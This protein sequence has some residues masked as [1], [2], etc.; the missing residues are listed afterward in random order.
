[1]G[2]SRKEQKD[3]KTNF[4]ALRLTFPA[5]QTDV[6][7][8]LWLLCSH[9]HGAFVVNF[10]PR[11]RTLAKRL[12]TQSRYLRVDR[13]WGRDSAA[14]ITG[15]GH[16]GNK[17][18]LSANDD[19]TGTTYATGFEFGMV[20]EKLATIRCFWGCHSWNRKRRYKWMVQHKTDGPLW[21]DPGKDDL[22]KL[23]WQNVCLLW[24]SGT[25]VLLQYVL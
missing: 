19:K 15:K 8:I 13:W 4:T 2:K 14:R 23:W 6:V 17:S 11:M 16:A 20:D 12:C 22:G 10:L 25:P 24:L 5:H 3:H 9:G 1:M 7:P 18:S 21:V